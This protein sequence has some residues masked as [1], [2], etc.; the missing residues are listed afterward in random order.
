[1]KLSGFTLLEMMLALALSSLLVL[2]MSDVFHIMRQNQKRIDAQMHLLDQER[3]LLLFFRSQMRE[4]VQARIIAATKTPAWV[5]RKPVRSAIL[6]L[7]RNEKKSNPAREIESAYYLDRSSTDRHGL[8]LFEKIKSRRREAL[9][10]SVKRLTLRAFF[11]KS[12][13]SGGVLFAFHLSTGVGPSRLFSFY[14]K[15]GSHE[16]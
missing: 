16:R 7:K 3:F 2:G 10:S 11:H 5:S 12:T 9:L 13:S 14:L 4:C 8:S 15:V 6:L 1:V